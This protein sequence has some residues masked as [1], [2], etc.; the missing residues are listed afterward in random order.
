MHATTPRTLDFTRNPHPA[1]VPGASRDQSIETMWS[2]KTLPKP[3]SA[4]ARSRLAPGTGAGCGMRLKSS[5]EGAVACM[6]SP[7]FRQPRLT[8]N[9]KT[10]K[11]NEINGKCCN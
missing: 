10:R 11:S 5:V 6:S 3:G 9:F 7:V 1:P 8:E 2:V 4:I